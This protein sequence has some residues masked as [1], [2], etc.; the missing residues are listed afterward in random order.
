[1]KK[2]LVSIIIPY[3]NKK[4]FFK[5]SFNSAY[6]Q[7]YKNKEIIIIYDDENLSDL[8]FIKKIIFKKKKVKL[9]INKKNLGAGLSRN[10]GINKSTGKYLAFLDSDDIWYKKKLENQIKFMNKNKYLC[11][12]TSYKIVDKKKNFISIRKAEKK[13]NYYN[14][15]N[16]CDIGLST[17]VLNKK[18]LGKR[19]RFPNLKT[20]E[21]YVLWL[22]IA[23]KRI[24]FYGLNK[25]L[26][27]WRKLDNSLSSNSFQKL[28][29]G[30]MVYKKYMKYGY[31]KSFYFLFNLVFN[32]L[33]KSF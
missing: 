8:K 20:K 6:N 29:D 3:Y 24:S 13:L 28:T 33:K 12:F 31:I 17:V 9:L 26:T 5:Q 21:D 2:E 23:K 16:S 14:L 4:L 18:V 25:E 22:N 7:T 32:F 10:F 15:L 27:V 1:M 19:L 30:F 11:T